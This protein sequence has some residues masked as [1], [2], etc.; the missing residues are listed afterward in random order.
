MMKNIL[1]LFLFLP[2]TL[3]CQILQPDD[4]LW[5]ADRKLKKEDY[6]IIIYDSE[7]PVRSG[8][9]LSWQ[10]AGFSVLNKN[11]NK[12]VTNRFS[13]NSSAL[14]PDAEDVEKLLDYQQTVFDLSEVYA[15]R[16]RREL[17]IRKNELWKGFEAANLILN[18]VSSDFT[19]VHLIMDKE[20]KF[21]SDEEKLR[22]W[23]EKIS[24]ELTGISDFDY[25][26][27]GK[28]NLKKDQHDRF[29]NPEN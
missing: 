21:G 29:Q 14:N 16:M 20:T 1:I 2:V 4:V 28:I 3:F 13:G 18:Q 11:F 17:L 24:D 25:Y 8:I 23:K 7:I 19:R 22:I 27:K 5:S 9:S 6:K 15:R 26:N 12:N 10:L